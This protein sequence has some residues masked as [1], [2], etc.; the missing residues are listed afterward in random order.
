MIRTKIV[1]VRPRRVVFVVGTQINGA[2]H[3]GTNIVQTSA[4]LL[5]KFARRVLAAGRTFVSNAPSSAATRLARRV[6]DPLVDL[7]VLARLAAV[8]DG[9]F[10]YLTH[11]QS[12]AVA[13]T[14]DLRQ[15]S[16]V[17]L[18]EE[19]SPSVMRLRAGGRHPVPRLYAAWLDLDPATPAWE[20]VAPQCGVVSH[21][22]AARLWGVSA[23]PGSAAE[24]TVPHRPAGP[25]P[26]GVSLHVGAL[27][28]HQWVERHGLPVTTPAQTLADLAAT[29]RLDGAELGRVAW[30]MMSAGHVSED[31]LA[32]GLGPN[33]PH[34]SANL[35]QWLDAADHLDG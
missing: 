19:L 15:L 21:A 20:R 27:A 23:G 6:Y 11:A 9:Q 33:H 5:A 32:A 34:P 25:E 17:G 2:P 1:A 22:A 4:F 29:G 24:F 18:A 13:P 7:N 31:A 16:T 28:E 12:S 8:A 35:R 14:G 26:S 30:A 3:L 10:G